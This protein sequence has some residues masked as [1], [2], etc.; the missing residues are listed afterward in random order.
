MEPTD[1]WDSK[2]NRLGSFSVNLPWFQGEEAKNN[3]IEA[4]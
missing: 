1:D 4:N 2:L 3:K